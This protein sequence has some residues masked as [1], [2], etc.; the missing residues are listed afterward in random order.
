MAKIKLGQ[1]L[2]R[3]LANGLALFSIF[4]VV[5]NVLVTAA[6]S[7]AGSPILDATGLPLLLGGMS[8]FSA[9]GIEISKDLESE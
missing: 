7:I 5:G 2:V 6:N 1:R 4:Y 3:A 9:V 8:L